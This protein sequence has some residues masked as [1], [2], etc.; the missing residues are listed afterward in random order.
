MTELKAGKECEVGA[1]SWPRFRQD[2]WVKAQMAE[3]KA[4]SR[5]STE[6]NNPG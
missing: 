4:A 1:G 3:N 6:S 5:L 2:A